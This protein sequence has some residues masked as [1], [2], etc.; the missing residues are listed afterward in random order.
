MKNL[1]ELFTKGKRN[2]DD[3]HPG[4]GKTQFAHQHGHENKTMSKTV[5]QC[6]MK[7][8]GDKT[9]NAPGNCPVCNMKLVAVK[10]STGSH[11][12]SQGCC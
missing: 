9:Y 6:P 7:C 12:H 5:Y 1:K 3:T 11:G 10:S 2:R 4:Y 8:E